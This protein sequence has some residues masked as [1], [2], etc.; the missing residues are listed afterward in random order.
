MSTEKPIS[1][2]FINHEAGRRQFLKNV[3]GI[4]GGLALVGTAGS[5]LEACSGNTSSPTGI[6]TPNNASTVV[7]NVASLIADAMSLVT[8]DK[9]SY[10]ASMVVYRASAGTYVVHSMKC[11]HAGCN[12][13]NPSGAGASALMQCPCHSSSFSLLGVVQGGPAPSNLQAYTS[14][15]DAA[16][17]ML[18]IKIK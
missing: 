16:T 2:N 6:G 8:A 11:T 13:G 14:T 7:V 1:V 17:D 12:I 3:G 15:W 18:T 5:L 10:G 9:D 4:V